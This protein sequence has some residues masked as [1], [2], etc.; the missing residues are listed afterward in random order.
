M[1][2]NEKEVRNVLAVK[3]AAMGSQKAFAEIHLLSEQ[4]LSDVLLGRRPVSSAI[5]KALGIERMPTTWYV[6]SDQG[7]DGA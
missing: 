2:L 1:I 6:H 5:E 4:F 3:V 7:A